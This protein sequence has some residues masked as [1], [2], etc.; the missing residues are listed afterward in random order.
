MLSR[1]RCGLEQY[2]WIEWKRRTHL[3]GKKVEGIAPSHLIRLLARSRSAMYC[4]C[5]RRGDN[6]RVE[7]T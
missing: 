2:Q 1:L 7:D 6:G 3:N 5:G 4:L